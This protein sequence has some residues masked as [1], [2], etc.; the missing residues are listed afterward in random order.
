[1]RAIEDPGAASAQATLR[2]QARSKATLAVST[3]ET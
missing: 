2:R 3:V 1:M